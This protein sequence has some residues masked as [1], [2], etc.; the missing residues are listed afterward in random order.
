MRAILIGC[1]VLLVALPA[2]A[3]TKTENAARCAADDPDIK[4]AG[5]TAMIDTPDESRENWAIAYYNRGVALYSKGFDQKA[6]SD[7][8]M[9]LALAPNDAETYAHRGWSYQRTRQNDH[10][11][12]DYS[13]VIVR[14]TT[15]VSN[16]TGSRRTT[17]APC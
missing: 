8:S 9:A 11:I 16:R 17:I 14:S 1:I 4:N 15:T 3:Q 12:A 6:I 13:K 5:C 2:L 10:A 7:F